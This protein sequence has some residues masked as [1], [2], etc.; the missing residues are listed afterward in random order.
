[1]H[2][3]STLSLSNNISIVIEVEIQ[4]VDILRMPMRT[5][6]TIE[7][8][9]TTYCFRTPYLTPL[10]PQNADKICFLAGDSLCDQLIV[11]FVHNSTRGV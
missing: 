7:E 6:N 2:E 3:M 8:K 11:I 1:M 5:S 10:A 9:N 4:C